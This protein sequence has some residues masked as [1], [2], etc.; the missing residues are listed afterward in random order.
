M[1]TPILATPNETTGWLLETS[2]NGDNTVH[3]AVRPGGDVIAVAL[4]ALD[5]WYVS[6]CD[7][8]PLAPATFH[9]QDDAVAWLT[10]LADLNTRPV[11]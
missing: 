3:T 6:L 10:Y 1:S 5:H 2:G 9:E 4:N 7:G 8:T 11:A